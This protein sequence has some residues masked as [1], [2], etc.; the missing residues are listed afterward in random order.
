MHRMKY[1]ANLTYVAIQRKAT[2][3]QRSL[4]MISRFIED[5]IAKIIMCLQTRK[6][7]AKMKAIQKLI[8]DKT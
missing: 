4:A 2:L 7:L 6:L 8:R 1:L 5:N 3:E